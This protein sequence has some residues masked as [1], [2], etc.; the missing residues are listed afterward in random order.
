[1]PDTGCPVN[2]KARQHAIFAKGQRLPEKS[3]AGLT[4]GLEPQAGAVRPRTIEIVT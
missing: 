2:G 1:M 4:A 3:A